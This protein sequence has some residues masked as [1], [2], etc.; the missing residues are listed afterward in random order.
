MGIQ[1]RSGVLEDV[2]NVIVELRNFSDFFGTEKS[3]FGTEEHSRKVI[4]QQINDHVFFVAESGDEFVGFISG[5]INAHPYNPDIKMLSES[6]W[7]IKPKFRGS[8]AAF[9]LLEAF[10]AF[11][12]EC[13]DCIT[14]SVLAD[15]PIKESTLTRRG[16]HL[17][18]KAYLMEVN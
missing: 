9:L 17:K 18:E 5:Y 16:F 8:R 1:V 13:A 11:G 14:M 7:W 4:E 12:K 2:P 15:S 6:F 10:T 3:L